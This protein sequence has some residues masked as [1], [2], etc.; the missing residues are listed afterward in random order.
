LTELRNF[1]SRESTCQ[2]QLLDQLVRVGSLKPGGNIGLWVLSSNN[3]SQVN[4]LELVKDAGALQPRLGG[5]GGLS[6]EDGDLGGNLGFN[7]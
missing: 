6:W 3:R 5:S 1:K 7:C 2:G 4:V